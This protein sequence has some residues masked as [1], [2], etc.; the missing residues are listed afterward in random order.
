MMNVYGFDNLACKTVTV[1]GVRFEHPATA[2]GYHYGTDT[3]KC[4]CNLASLFNK[5]QEK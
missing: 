3:I 2:E 4:L 5:V 1:T